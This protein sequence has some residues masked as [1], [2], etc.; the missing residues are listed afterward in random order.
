MF[1]TLTSL[2]LFW[3]VQADTTSQASCMVKDEA[4]FF[5]LRALEKPHG[6]YYS[7]ENLRWNFCNYVNFVGTAYE[8]ISD[9]PDTMA[10]LENAD[11]GITELT[12]PSFMSLSTKTLFN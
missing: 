1:K 12:I 10:F 7:Y 4:V 3:G 5:D 9:A 2:A 6:E 11:G 8:G